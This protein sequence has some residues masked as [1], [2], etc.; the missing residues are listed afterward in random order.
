MKRGNGG[1]PYREHRPGYHF[2]RKISIPCERDDLSLRGRQKRLLLLR[3]MMRRQAFPDLRFHRNVDAPAPPES[4]TFNHER[5]DAIP[6]GG[7]QRKTCSRMLIPAS[8]P[9][10]SRESIYRRRKRGFSSRGS[11]PLLLLGLKLLDGDR[12]RRI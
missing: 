6:A 8:I 4:K 5:G 1:S 11:Q 9:R 12:K 3:L 7:E 2:L 10:V